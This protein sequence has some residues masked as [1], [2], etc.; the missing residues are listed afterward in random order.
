LSP[1]GSA[2][3]ASCAAEREARRPCARCKVA[4]AVA[5]ALPATHA[6]RVPLKTRRWN[7][8]AEPDDGARILVCRFRPRGVKKADE[9]WDEWWK[10]LGPSPALHAAAYGKGQPMISWP[11]YRRRYLD[12]IADDPGRFHLRALIERAAAGETLT[13]LCSSACQDAAACHRSILVELVV[14]AL[15]HQ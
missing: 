9:T 6:C 4:T 1:T 11:E 14:S 12:E 5:V 13:L 15:K 2:T 7:D 8:P 10:E 3:L